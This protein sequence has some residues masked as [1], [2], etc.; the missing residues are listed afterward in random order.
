MTSTIQRASALGSWTRAAAMTTAVLLA[1]ILGA[2]APLLAQEAP[3]LVL[4]IEDVVRTAL[5]QSR[6]IQAARLGLE[7]ADER[8]SEAWSN[9]YPSIDLDASYTRNVSPAVSFLPAIIF[10]PEAPP[11]EYVAL[12]FGADN[13]FTSTLSVE[14]AL[15]RPSVFVALGAAGSFRNLQNEA[16]RGSTQTVITRVRLVYY[17]LLLAQEQLRLVENSVRR[18]RES[19]VEMRALAGAGLSSEYDVLRLEV[20]LANLERVTDGYLG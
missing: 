5:R 6:D 18:V 15:F 13:Q 2:A 1:L 20:E 10:D 3:P 17:Q 4:G 16:V 9:V 8:V 11:G 12:Q 7:E 14:Q 19:L